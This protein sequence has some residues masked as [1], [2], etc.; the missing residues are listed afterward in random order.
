MGNETNTALAVRDQKASVIKQELANALARAMP[1]LPSHLRNQETAQRMMRI[2]WNAVQKNPRLLDCTPDSIGNSALTACEL[3]L[4]TNVIG[5]AF[6]VPF[7]NNKKNCL[8]C[9][10]M[11]GYKGLLKL[12]RNSGTVASIYADVVRDGDIFDYEKGTSPFLRHKPNA[13]DP[14]ARITHAYFVVKFTNGESQFEVMN[15]S[16]IERV[17]QKTQSKDR[18]T[19]EVYG[20]WIDNFEE[21]AKKTVVKRGLKLVEAS[22]EVERA[23]AMDDRIEAG[24]P[25]ESEYETLPAA[26]TP[27]PAEDAK[28][29]GARGRVRTKLGVEP[30]QPKDMGAAEVIQTP[31]AT[32]QPEP[33]RAEEREPD[34]SPADDSGLTEDQKEALDEVLQETAPVDPPTE[35][36]QEP[37][38]CDICAKLMDHPYSKTKHNGKRYVFC[39][40]KCDARFMKENGLD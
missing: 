17:M 18:K 9:Q 37:V 19:G 15:R 6:L 10:L 3:G 30:E 20:P 14:E 21:M 25:Q 16:Q 11:P 24:L 36:K 2:V 7:W 26:T 40:D 22:V 23:V 12:A 38:A 27:A 39:S 33:T 5:H 32:E 4:E 13:D 29:K 8:E 31:Q 35:E 1:V 34:D 28:P